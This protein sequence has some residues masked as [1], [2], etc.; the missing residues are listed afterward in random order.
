MAYARE[1]D[2]NLTELKAYEADLDSLISI[3]YRCPKCRSCADCRDSITTERVSLREEDE[4][5]Q[6]RDS[7]KL[8]YTN[9]RFLCHLPLRGKPE[10]YLSTN[11]DGARKILAKQVSLYHQEED[12][13]A[14]IIKAMDKLFTNDHVT[15]LKDLP[16]EQQ[17]LILQ[18]PV[19]YF[20]PWRV[21]FKASSISTPARPVFDCSAKTPIT[22]DG[23]GGKCLNDLMAKG[24][25][26]SF[27]LIKMLLRF[28]IGETALSG[29][30]S[31]FYNVFKL[32][33]EYWHLQLFLWQAEL[34]P[35]NAVD[36]AVIKTLIYGNSA[37]APLSEEGM[38]QLAALVREH[39]PELADF[40]INGR[41]VD[42]LN[43]STE[44]LQ[45]ALR[46]KAAVDDAFAKLGVKIKG[47]AIARHPPAPEISE[48]GYVGVAGMAWHTETDTVELKLN[49]L[50]FGKAVRGR[51][52][53]STPTFKG[54]IKDTDA[55]NKFVPKIL[56]KRMITSK[57]MGIFDLKGMLIP[58]TGRFKRDL[59]DISTTTP[60]WDHAVDTIGRSKWVLNFLDVERLKGM[61]FTRPRMP[62]DAI[63]IKMRLWILVDASKHLIVI[64]AGVGFKRANGQ[65]S[66]A[67]LVARCLL[68][69]RGM[70]IPRAE[71]ESLVGGSNMMWMLR[72]ILAKWVDSFILA[73]DARIPL[74]WI[75]SDKH[76]LSLWHRTRSAQIRRGTPNEHI[77]HVISAA[78]V[79]DIP[80]RPN[81]CSIS[82]VG[83][84]SEWEE[85]KP[86]MQKD[87]STLVREG[88]LTPISA[89][90]NIEEDDKAE[91]MEGMVTPH[92]PD[93]LTRGYAAQLLPPQD[94]P[95]GRTKV[96]ARALHSKYILLPTAF[97]FPK[98]VRIMS[99]VKRFINAF[100]KKW[101]PKFNAATAPNLP[102]NFKT[103]LCTPSSKPLETTMVF[104]AHAS[105]YR[106]I[107]S[108][109]WLVELDNTPTPN[110]RFESILRL[111]NDDIQQ[112]LLYYYRKATTEVET[113]VPA[114]RINKHMYRQGGL[115]YHRSRINDGQRR[116][117]IA[118]AGHHELATQG[119]NIY[120]PVV[121]RW[122]PLAYSLGRWIHRTVSDHAGFETALRHSLNYCF[123]I[124]GH[125]LF[126][127]LGRACTLCST[128]RSRFTQAAMGPRNPNSYSIAPAFWIAQADLFG[129]VL[130]YVPGRE[131]NTRN[132]PSSSTRCWVMVFT[133]LLSKAINL[134]VVE[135][136]SAP[137]L[138][139]GLSRMSCEVGTPARLL[140]DQDSVFMTVLNEA[141]V[142]LPDIETHMRLRATMDFQLCPVSGHNFHGQVEARI[143]TVQ[144][145]LEKIGLYNERIHATGLQT[146]LKL[147]E[148]DINST[149]LGVTMRRTATNT[150]LL[151][152]I[153][154]DHLKLG[155]ISNRIPEGPFQLPNSPKDMISRAEE[156]YW[157]WH[158]MFN[159]TLL[160]VLLAAD[161]PK[162]YNHDTD[163]KEGDAVYF[164]KS[165]GATRSPWSMGIVDSVDIG[166]DGLI[167]H[168]A[169]KYYDASDP[170]TPH[171]SDRAIRSL[172]RIFNVDELHW[173]ED[174][175]RIRRICQ[176][177]NLPLAPS[178]IG[179]NQ[180]SVPSNLSCGCCCHPHHALKSTAATPP[181][182][183]PSDSP[184]IPNK[185]PDVM[186]YPP[187]DDMPD[188]L[189]DA[190][191]RD[192]LD[193]QQDTF[194]SHILTLGALPFSVGQQP[195]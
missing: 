16:L 56:T 173:Q 112:G 51:L 25:S 42:D 30:I 6:I 121:D 13:K 55:M 175:D 148:S 101:D 104:N 87:I 115:L 97:S 168:A 189:L 145:A 157:R 156:L 106:P 27:E 50:H 123:I 117:S 178:D 191:A 85:G 180:T 54:S 183:F 86:W 149:P 193:P 142:T 179:V 89:L 19:M 90:T 154:P 58:L 159:S 69:P 129:P 138:A 131:Q 67:F 114:E 161:Q 128:L 190:G 12:T 53:P 36:I 146:A 147:I 171:T 194:L 181:T 15:L 94:D 72:Q 59:R 44:S 81:K 3:E 109:S 188:I 158:D 174:M 116:P 91:Y 172:V 70:S 96:E 49:D 113:F 137:L 43:E 135:G 111:T 119:I 192:E 170:S 108:W 88:T 33:P 20:I 8:D 186:P 75:L 60:H 29:D 130:T 122:S 105:Y 124:H 7:V 14:M 99:I 47:W 26:M 95:S 71:M 83:P 102:A 48:D 100:R 57:F 18:A 195:F 164:K 80:T 40:L 38:R 93:A 110:P 144:D 126:E 163:L 11:K 127:E 34:D 103:F 22:A 74:F 187:A 136:H 155:R 52:N 185:T 24:K 23:S 150:P 133:C 9:Q 35:N 66:I 152:L 118:G 10:E 98:V 17:A 28:S 182:S 167:R 68:V 162:W 120:L 37:S 107:R 184:L 84:G 169:V 143:K 64:W 153:T 2:P 65:W 77:Y 32:R 78:N 134:Q 31:Q 132:D 62:V 73:G 160:P 45:A 1:Y 165:T 21:V 151:Q 125:S 76:R 5:A 140:I 63:N 41:F 4:E 82:D 46:L 61:K 166:R 39:D 92:I 139:Q 176:D 79:A 177:T 141:E